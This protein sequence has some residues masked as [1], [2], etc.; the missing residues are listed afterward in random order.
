ME[1]FF[2]IAKDLEIKGLSNDSIVNRKEQ[3]NSE[4]K[5]DMPSY[6]ETSSFYD[7]YAPQSMLHG[8]S[9]HEPTLHDDLHL[10][11]EVIE[12]FSEDYF[13]NTD[14]F[15]TKQIDVKYIQQ[16]KTEKQSPSSVKDHTGR[17]PCK[18]CEY[19][20]TSQT[21]LKIHANAIHEGVR[22]PCNHCEYKAT[23]KSSLNCNMI[24]HSLV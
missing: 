10:N 2:A 11:E 24:R 14:M 9:G 17:Y 16:T 19:K 13:F 12:R 8:D 21:N 1:R 7:D 15:N 6:P 4:T 5:V 22:Y 20:A 3:E 18:K 23:Q